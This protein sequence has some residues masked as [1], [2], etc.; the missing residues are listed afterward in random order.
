MYT[1]Q[2]KP[3]QQATHI[4]L[5]VRIWSQTIH[6]SRGQRIATIRLVPTWS[7]QAPT[8]EEILVTT[9][10]QTGRAVTLGHLILP[11]SRLP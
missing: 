5:S 4:P 3:E 1:L 8:P 6:I 7:K 9:D 11:P 10:R 2:G